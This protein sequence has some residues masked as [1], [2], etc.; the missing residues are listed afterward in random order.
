ML[1]GLI[2]TKLSSY[3]KLAQ[4]VTRTASDLE[5]GSADSE[6]FRDLGNDLEEL[7]EKLRDTNEETSGLLNDTI[8]PPTSTMLHTLQRQRDVMQEYTREFART[9]TNAQAALDKVNL[10]NN[11]RS[12]I[13]SYKAAHSSVTDSLLGERSRID[14]SHQMMDETLNQVYATRDEFGSQRSTLSGIN[15]RMGGVLSTLPGINSL[16]GMIHSRRRRDSIII[17]CLIGSLTLFL[18]WYMTG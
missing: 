14:S 6:R 12:D 2:Q 1:E 7:L 10:L 17:G 3:S 8:N 15:T 11:V 9:K 13:N 4:S 16:L 18:F 5:A